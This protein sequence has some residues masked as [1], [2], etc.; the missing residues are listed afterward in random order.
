M[1]RHAC[2]SSPMRCRRHLRAPPPAARAGRT[3]LVLALVA[4]P[5]LALPLATDSALGLSA[6]SSASAPVDS[7]VLH[8]RPR[9][10]FADHAAFVAAGAPIHSASV[11]RHVALADVSRR[12]RRPRRLPCC[13]DAVALPSSL[14]D[15]D[16]RRRDLGSARRGQPPHPAPLAQTCAPSSVRSASLEAV[17]RRLGL[18]PVGVEQRR[19]ADLVEAR[20]LVVVEHQVGGAEVVGELLL[21]A[22]AD[23]HARRRPGARA[24][25]RAR[26]GRARR[27]APR[28]SPRARRRCRR[29]CPRRGSA[30]RSSRS[31][32]ASPPACPGRGGT[33][34]TAGRRR[35][36]S[37][38]GS[39]RPGRARA[40]TS[41]YSAS[42]A[43]SV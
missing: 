40:G 6:S 8:P 19:R 30:A 35:A 11:Q 20:A 4:L 23:D 33:C 1:A 18:V 9:T 7:R 28:R 25:T 29:A 2:P 14:S 34:P 12:A 31:D 21:G 15:T 38:R 3:L 37:T 13:Y 32:G 27:R 24:A 42:R 22:R 36:G 17:A 26:P 10:C 41:S 43:C 39:R 16:P 5:R